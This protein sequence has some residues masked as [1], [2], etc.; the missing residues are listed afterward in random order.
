MFKTIVLSFLVAP[1]GIPQVVASAN[2]TLLRVVIGLYASTLNMYF[3]FSGYSDIAVGAARMMG[4]ELPENFD[5]PYLRSNIQQ[6]WAAWHI[7]LTNW[8]T[9][10]IYWPLVRK[11]RPLA[12]LQKRPVLLSNVCIVVTFAICGM[13]HGVSLNFIL[14]GFYHGLGIALMNVYRKYKRKA[15]NPVLRDYFMSRTSRILG[16]LVTINFFVLGIALFSL[17]MAGIRLLL[18]SR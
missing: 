8:L 4:F 18:S 16:V 11:L 7:S 10:Y 3:N 5:K 14:W 1:Y 15:K 13:W 17:D 9:D 12:F 6:F 2:P